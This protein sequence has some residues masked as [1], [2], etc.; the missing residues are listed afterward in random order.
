M[1]ISL[2]TAASQGGVPAFSAYLGSAQTLAAGTLTKLQINTKEY[3]TANSYDNVTNYRFTPTVAG[4]Y[5]VIGGLYMGA[6]ERE[7]ILY[8]NG[9]LYRYLQA[10]NSSGSGGT[11]GATLIYLNGS[12]D[13]IELYGYSA[14]GGAVS[15]GASTTY[16]QAVMV[17]AA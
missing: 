1:A 6:V 13:Y 16:F 14:A 12:T 15:T 11:S 7:A 10:V 17:R 8:K 2:I 9:S 3:D 5:M 4:Y